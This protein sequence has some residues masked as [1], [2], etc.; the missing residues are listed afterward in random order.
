MMEK[1]CRKYAPKASPRPLFSFG[2]QSMHVIL[3]KIR[4][5]KKD[6]QKS[7]KKLA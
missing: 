6:Y 2:N 1:I 3:L 5:L 4:Y 7:L